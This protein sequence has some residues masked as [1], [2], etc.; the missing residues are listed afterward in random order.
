MFKKIPYS[1]I[2]LVNGL[3]IYRYNI[4]INGTTETLGELYSGEGYAFYENNEDVY[5]PEGELIPPEEVQDT[6]RNLMTYRTLSKT[7]AILS[8]EQ[9]RSMFTVV[10]IPCESD[11]L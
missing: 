8:N 6:D 2:E 3:F 7:S 9:I 11:N 4:T 1:A 10:K 5:T